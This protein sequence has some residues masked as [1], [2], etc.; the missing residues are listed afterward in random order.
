MRLKDFDE[1]KENGAMKTLKATSLNSN[2][3]NYMTNNEMLVVDFDKAKTN[4][5]NKLKKSEEYAS[6][7]DALCKT[8][9]EDK[10]YL[11]EFKDGDFEPKE[12]RK[13][14]VDS[15]YLISGITDKSV[16]F[17]RENITFVLVYNGN[18]KQLDSRQKRALALASRGREDYAIWGLGKLRGFYYDDVKVYEKKEFNK[19]TVL[20]KIVA[21][22]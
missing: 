14:A 21:I 4:Y 1:F 15:V 10:F 2:S 22:Q 20:N 8:V 19:S 16:N 3:D 7:A 9:Y 13:K 6:S 11:I 18:V 12:I 5:C 17:I